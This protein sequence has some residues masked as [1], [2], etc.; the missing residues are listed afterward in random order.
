MIVLICASEVDGESVLA[1]LSDRGNFHTILP[2]VHLPHELTSLLHGHTRPREKVSL[3]EKI[4]TPTRFVDLYSLAF[5]EYD[6]T[7]ASV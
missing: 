7:L 2:L 1:T 6:H 5:Q 3:H 4:L